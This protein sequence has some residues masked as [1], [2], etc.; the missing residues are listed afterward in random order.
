MSEA[1]VQQEY[2]RIVTNHAEMD[3][4]L[5]KLRMRGKDT[6][7]Q[8]TSFVKDTILH[9]EGGQVHAK[10]F[11]PMKSVWVRLNIPFDG[12]KQEGQLV[13]GD[14]SEFL[15]Y[16]GRFGEQTIVSQELPDDE[17]TYHL[18]FNDEDRKVG[19]YPAKDEEHIKSIQQAD[20]LPYQFDPEEDDHPAAP[21]KNVYLD[22]WFRCDVKEVLDILEDGDTTQIR[23]YPMNV[24]DGRV[25]VRVGDETG[26]IETEFVASEGDGEAASVY[27][28]GMHNVFS[29]LSG[30]VTVYL[31]TDGALWVQQTD[32]DWNLDYMIAEDEG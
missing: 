9:F 1:E 2:A 8:T 14:I 25:Q 20:Q 19:G 16:L 28:Y 24:E 12:I 5:S 23:K 17:N 15:S 27:S 11:D 21:S 7:G 32:E 18:R 22:T 13:I 31:D 3:D 10:A 26:Y 29:N 30:E 4:L 6:D